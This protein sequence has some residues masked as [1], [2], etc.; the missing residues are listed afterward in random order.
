[1][2]LAMNGWIYGYTPRP[3]QVSNNLRVIWH[4]N[5]VYTQPAIY[6]NSGWFILGFTLWVYLMTWIY[7]N[8][9]FYG[10]SI[11]TEVC[12]R[13]SQH[14]GMN[15]MEDIKCWF[16]NPNK[17]NMCFQTAAMGITNIVIEH[18]WTTRT[19]VWVMGAPSQAMI[20]IYITL[21]NL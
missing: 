11:S 12:L 14:R 6:S 15:W 17:L 2:F 5:Q 8:T 10:G 4:T 21:Y 13:K 18:D 20:Y 16:K 1:M 19:R 9:T 3:V 7:L